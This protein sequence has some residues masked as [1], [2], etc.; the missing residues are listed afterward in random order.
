MTGFDS[1]P[2]LSIDNQV[3]SLGQALGYLQLFGQL[4]PFVQ[5]ILKY[6][7]IY[8]EIQ[9]HP[10]L[11]ISSA[12]M[13]QAVIEFR[14]R[15]GLADPEQFQHWLTL[16]GIDYGVFESQAVVSLKLEK[17]KQQIS[18][19]QLETCFAEQQHFLDQVDL[20]YL[21]ISEVELAQSIQ[22]RLAAGEMAEAVAAEL[23]AIAPSEAATPD[24]RVVI[25]RD[26]LRRQQLRPEIQAAVE[27]APL[28]QWV[29]PIEMG[30]HQCVLRVEQV[31]PARL[32]EGVRQ[33]LQEL[34]FNQWVA[35]KLKNMTVTAVSSSI[36]TE[37][38]NTALEV[39]AD[40]EIAA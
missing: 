27:T 4:Q 28:Q 29:G 25:K 3:V 32:D 36:S 9:N 37:P 40:G 5:N 22:A 19:A 7:A 18:T 39:P 20:H 6:H 16:Q 8:Q 1:T 10:D 13:G 11:V 17:L 24:P 21:V 15:S 34:L 35:S 33:E 2:F 38:G 23:R 12:E 31:L 30:N 26:V 14:L